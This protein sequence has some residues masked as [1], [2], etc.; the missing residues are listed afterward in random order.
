MELKLEENGKTN[1]AEEEV[2]VDGNSCTGET[3][4]L[5]R[6]LFIFRNIVII[7]SPWEAGE[8]DKREDEKCGGDKE[9]DEV[10]V[11]E[12]RVVGHVLLVHATGQEQ[13]KKSLF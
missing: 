4:T 1:Q 7:A 10:E 6:L 8:D 12:A 11:V 9:A 2:S 5:L 3:E 13:M